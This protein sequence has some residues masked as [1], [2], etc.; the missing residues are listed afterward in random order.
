MPDNLAEAHLSYLRS[1]SSSPYTPK[2]APVEVT[3]PISITPLA[4]SGVRR[5]VRR[6]NCDGPMPV[7]GGWQSPVDPRD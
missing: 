6:D 5:V 1:L 2:G 3:S 7:Q 4:D